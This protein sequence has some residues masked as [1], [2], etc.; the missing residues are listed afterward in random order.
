MG[1]VFLFSKI[2]FR[3]TDNLTN[4]SLSLLIILLLNPFAVKDIG[5]QLSFLGT[6][7]IIA[8]SKN[9]KEILMKI[10]INEKI[11]EI[12]SVTISAQIAIIPIIMINFNNISLTFWIS[13]FLV[14][15]IIGYIMFVGIIII[16]LPICF[17]TNIFSIFLNFLLEILIFIAKTTSIIPFS[18]IIIT[19]PNMIIVV[20]YY[21]FIFLINYIYIIIFKIN[22]NEN[23]NYYTYTRKLEKDIYLFIY[24]LVCKIKYNILNFKNKRVRNFM[25]KIIIYLFI[26]ILTL[27]IYKQLPKNFLIYFIDVGQRR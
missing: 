25:K 6:I 5:L 22:K 7:G 20:F 16:I 12:L 8:F 19:T 27:N 15:P 21:I 13:N 17:L 14:A 1:G 26:L 24:R 10:K 18:N 4:I 2:V 23:I 11:S 9:I 3:K